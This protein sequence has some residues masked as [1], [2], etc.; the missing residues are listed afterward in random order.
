MLI[1]EPTFYL[2]IENKADQTDQSC[3]AL[4]SRVVAYTGAADLRL[5]YNLSAVLPST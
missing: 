4:S 1:K 5:Q 2:E 3:C